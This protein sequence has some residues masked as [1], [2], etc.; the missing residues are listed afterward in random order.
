MLQE[1]DKA[2]CDRSHLV[3]CYIDEV[4]LSVVNNREVGT[5]TSLDTVGVDEVTVIGKL[6]VRLCYG[7]TLLLLS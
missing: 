5:Q 3:R 7:L 2:R 6:L 4:Y 1:W